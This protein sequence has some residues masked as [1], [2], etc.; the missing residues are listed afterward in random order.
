MLPDFWGSDYD[1]MSAHGE[2]DA[3]VCVECEDAAPAVTVT[4]V[5]PHGEITRID[6]CRECAERV[7]YGE[8]RES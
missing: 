1:Y 8:D 6:V 7:G 4:L 5:D 3:P 2:P